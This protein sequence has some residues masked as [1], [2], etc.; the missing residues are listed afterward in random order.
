MARLRRAALAQPHR[1]VR[2]RQ[3]VTA[4]AAAGH[5]TEA[6]RS[7]GDARR[8][9]AEFGMEPCREV[10]DIERQLLGV[11]RTPATVVP[12]AGPARPDGRS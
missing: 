7:I 1:E 4:L 5:G 2:W 9:L 6:L 10:V 12:G 8:A 3:L 11:G